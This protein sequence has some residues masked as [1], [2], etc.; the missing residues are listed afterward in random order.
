[1]QVRLLLLVLSFVHGERP[2]YSS[3]RQQGVHWQLVEGSSSLQDALASYGRGGERIFDWAA[4]AV[5]AIG[6]FGGLASTASMG[7]MSASV[8]AVGGQ[9]TALSSQVA[10]LGATVATMGTQVSALN[11]VAGPVMGIASATGLSVSLVSS[12]VTAG[13]LAGPLLG[14]SALVVACWPKEKEEDPF[15]RIESRVKQMIDGKMD[16]ARQERLASRLKRYLR[17]FARCTAV[18]ADM[19]KNPQD[20]SHSEAIGHF[21]QE[22]SKKTGSASG[23]AVTA[24]ATTGS[25]MQMGEDIVSNDRHTAASTAVEEGTAEPIFQSPPCMVHLER[26]MSLERDEWMTKKGSSLDS[27]FLPFATMHTQLLAFLK[28]FPP[29]QEPRYD[30]SQEQTSAEYAGFLLSGIVEAWKAQSCRQVR[31]RELL[32]PTQWPKYEV[33]VLKPQDQPNAGLNCKSQCGKLGWC[34]FCG[35]EGL[36]ACC[37]HQDPSNPKEC[38]RLTQRGPFWRNYMGISSSFDT[39]LHMDCQQKEIKYGEDYKRTMATDWSACQKICQLEDKCAFFT[40]WED[41]EPNCYLSPV[42]AYKYLHTGSVS[43]PKHC[44]TFKGPSGS[45]DQDSEAADVETLPMKEFRP[46]GESAKSISDQEFEKRSGEIQAYISKCYPLVFKEV[47]EDFNPLYLRFISAAQGFAEKAGC[48][49]EGLI[50]NENVTLIAGQNNFG[51]FSECKWGE[52]SSAPTEQWTP[53]VKRRESGMLG[54]WESKVNL[55]KQQRL[56]L[57]PAPEWLHARLP[58]FQ[59]LEKKYPGSTEEGA[60]AAE[61][62]DLVLEAVAKAAEKIQEEKMLETQTEAEVH[63]KLETLQENERP[64]SNGDSNDQTATS[65]AKSETIA[66]CKENPGQAV[67]MCSQV[68]EEACKI[69]TPGYDL[70]KEVF[71]RKCEQQSPCCT[72]VKE[73]TMRCV[74]L[75]E[76][77]SLWNEY[78]RQH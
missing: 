28:A 54:L 17:E 34:N 22:M 38:R 67:A 62:P 29:A 1:M 2:R 20:A 56:Q 46:C 13:A 69:G 36:G 8:A 16:E 52:E 64:T 19:A 50:G 4:G 45:G 32:V 6:E 31:L 49:H 7:Q 74:A 35:G 12:L 41:Y 66:W 43:G 77:Q 3:K 15:M 59:C 30:E 58:L 71:R 18:F 5:Q 48:S 68:P 33:T 57:F 42:T 26:I 10:G 27:L 60:S 39:C 76:I 24:A 72:P 75:E 9:V 11:A 14:A 21:K 51:D 25:L 23:S 70:C 61:S 63:Q 53:D 78:S 55:K 47:V 73:I 65:E 40:F 44:P 37:Q